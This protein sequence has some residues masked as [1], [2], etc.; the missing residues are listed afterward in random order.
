MSQILEIDLEHR[1]FNFKNIP[2]VKDYIGGIAVSY[3]LLNSYF[4]NDFKKRDYFSIVTGPLNGIF[5]Y[6]SKCLLTSFIGG[7]RQ[8]VYCGGSFGSNMNFNNIL[9]I[10]ILGKS[11]LPVS[12]EISS[13]SVK[14][15]ESQG[16]ENLG[17]IP[18]RKSSIVFTDVLLEE[19]YFNFGKNHLDNNLKK[20]SL[21]FNGEYIKID[22][23]FYSDLTSEIFKREKE[24]TVSRGSF[25]S[26]LGCPMGCSKSKDIDDVN[27]SLLSRCLISCGYASSIYSDV[28]IVFSCF[29][30]LG[31]NYNHDFLE[32]FQ[33]KVHDLI[34][35]VNKNF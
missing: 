23:D 5:P 18:S 28:N 34:N 9:A 20:I 24:L 8:S 1:S 16:E 6:T 26:C 3:F 31:L 30:L 12:L 22:Q 2:L 13:N 19:N 10:E 33:Y 11:L 17:G 35:S 27:A 7:L 32:K 15:L 14:F 4:E 21:L 29:Q 25:P